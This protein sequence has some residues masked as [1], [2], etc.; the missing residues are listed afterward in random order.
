MEKSSR[1]WTRNVFLYTMVVLI[2]LQLWGK[3]WLG[4]WLIHVRMSCL[5]RNIFQSR[6]TFVVST[7]YYPRV[8]VAWASS[9]HCHRI[10]IK[11]FHRCQYYKFYQ[12]VPHLFGIFRHFKSILFPHA[13]QSTSFP[14]PSF[15]LVY[16]RTLLR[17]L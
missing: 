1:R 7:E 17:A 2:Y 8:F 16:L 13:C 4:T 12:L 5:Q 14:L 9:I 15:D 6:F 3:A 10:T 11:K